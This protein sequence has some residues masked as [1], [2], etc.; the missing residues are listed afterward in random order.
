MKVAVH[1]QV[2]QVIEDKTEKEGKPR[3]NWDM[4]ADE[5][6]GKAEVNVS[7]QFFSL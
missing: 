1:S 4:F 7:F 5:A 2:S 3:N 6:P